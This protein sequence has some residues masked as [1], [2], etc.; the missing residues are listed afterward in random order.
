MNELVFLKLGGSLITN[1][2]IA[3]SARYDVITRIAG[4][5]A[6]ALRDNP[7]L[8]LLLGHG[9]GSFGHIPARQYGTRDG[10]R[11]PEEWRGFTAV[12][13]E[14][15]ALN[16]IV[17]ETLAEAGLPVIAFSPSS[18]ALTASQRVIAWDTT[19][20][21]LALESRLLPLVYGDVIFDME[22]GGTILS[23]EE[24]F[25]YL[26]G[27]LHPARVLLA[28]IEPGIW[29]DYPARSEV[30]HT[31][32]PNNIKEIDKHLAASDSPDVTGGMRSKVFSMLK[33]VQSG[34]CSEVR[35]F[36]GLEDRS[37]LDV[38]SGKSTGTRICLD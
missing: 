32:T 20:I 1:K 26:A 37:I 11:S 9:S 34:D 13:R 22:I 12:W 23:T 6:Q 38:I 14:A 5:V 33:L 8:R 28:G 15:K 29:K 27:Q 24:Q 21:Q 7:G 17:T 35:I 36:S 4:E 2:E 18:Q 31:I 10:V 3:H 16:T 30:F 19:Q 25:E